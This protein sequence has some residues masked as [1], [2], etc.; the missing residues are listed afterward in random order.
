[1]KILEIVET[2][3]LTEDTV[4][5]LNEAYQNPFDTEEA[6]A[7]YMQTVHQAILAI[8]D[9]KVDLSESELKAF[10]IRS[11]WSYV[12]LEARVEYFI[13][14]N[15]LAG[16]G[17]L[18][19]GIDIELRDTHI[20][21]LLSFM[22]G[23]YGHVAWDELKPY[24]E[25]LLSK[26]NGAEKSRYLE[27]LGRIGG[28]DKKHLITVMAYNGLQF[29]PM[30]L[31][32][33]ALHE[34]I[35]DNQGSERIVR[36]HPSYDPY[37]FWDMVLRC[38]DHIEDHYLASYIECHALP[39]P[40][41]LYSKLLHICIEKDL[42]ES[43][44]AYLSPLHKMHNVDR[45][46]KVILETAIAMLKP[47][48]VLA[49]GIT[50]L[51]DEI[52]KHRKGLSDEKVRSELSPID[53]QAVRSFELIKLMM[54]LMIHHAKSYFA[55]AVKPHKEAT[56]KTDIMCW[57]ATKGIN[58]QLCVK[59]LSQADRKGPSGMRASLSFLAK[60]AILNLLKCSSKSQYLELWRSKIILNVI[61]NS[62]DCRA[63][64]RALLF[65]SEPSLEAC[66]DLLASG[67][68]KS[69]GV[70]Y[71]AGLAR[72]QPEHTFWENIGLPWNYGSDL[73]DFVMVDSEDCGP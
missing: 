20:N 18:L 56:P 32:W 6:E 4:S 3:R 63:E 61:T 14:K 33:K 27:L 43:V 35:E 12:F 34:M 57:L 11:Q 65:E 21:H 62:K 1:M 16:I 8:R 26:C 51:F 66:K 44:R 5:Y 50:T 24:L 48:V 36:F 70:H 73:E 71:A 38:I 30:H 10:I 45:D 58:L 40:E 42:G 41:N 19:D 9:G 49:I 22:I 60:R 29:N 28:K 55:S 52:Y 53:F 47:Q 46:P 31:D 67:E 2:G 39:I 72:I 23:R 25:L 68:I 69:E 7:S 59:G 37:L 13:P 17:D 15:D 54:D 64:M